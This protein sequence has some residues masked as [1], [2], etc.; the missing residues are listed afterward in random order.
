MNNIKDIRTLDELKEFAVQN[1]DI[2]KKAA[3]P[4]TVV[5]ALLFFWLFGGGSNGQKS[6]S[7]IQ[8]GNYQ[9]QNQETEG[10]YTEY[11]ET[12][13]KSG[14]SAQTDS[15]ANIYVDISGC[16]NNPGVYEVQSGTRIFQLIEKAGGITKEADIT[17]VN[18]AEEVFDGQKIVIYSVEDTRQ[19]GLQ[20]GWQNSNTQGSNQGGKVNI[21]RA[22]SEEL[23]TISGIGPATA[24]KII[25]YREKE[26]AFSSI[27]DI[28]N[29]SGIGD[30]TFENLKEYIT[31]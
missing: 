22:T 10:E 19:G 8:N 5:A 23:Q 4:I 16:V 17:S 29:V 11:D 25:E 3:L 24:Q 14:E 18:R 15:S 30:K 13:L 26:G 28:K 9:E 6:D 21:N 31:V 7:D 1:R 20:S 27:E 12:A 2:I